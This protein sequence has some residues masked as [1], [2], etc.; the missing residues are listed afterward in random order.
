MVAT[1]GWRAMG[2]GA[3]GLM[4]LLFASAGRG[5]EG[6]EA[7]RG[8][9]TALAR[10]SYTWE[11]TARQRFAGET[12]TPRLEGNAPVEVRGK[13]DPNGCMEITLGPTRDL[14]VPVTALFRM[15][16]VVAQTPIGWL[17]RGALRQTPNAER[18]VEFA[19]KQVRLSRVLSVAMKATAIR[20]LA[21]E[22]FDLIAD[23]KTWRTEQGL[24]IA[25]LREAT[26]EQLWGAP[27]ARRAPEIHGTVIFKIGETGLA[28]Y[29]V[30]LGIGFPSSRTKK[31]AWTMQQWTTRVS[32]VG[33]TTVEPPEAAL[34]ALDAE[35]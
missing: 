18:S 31:I 16:D 14:P 6:D 8:A 1:R 24:V 33:A 4:G 19:G 30:V 15:G 9:V 11:T 29:H 21:E 28:E 3:L 5:A 13:V 17:R 10:T 27:D 34:Q 2:I 7:A 35:R 32:G 23:V 12:T 22:L 26:I 20:P 25:E